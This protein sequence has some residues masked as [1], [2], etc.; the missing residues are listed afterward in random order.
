MCLD[1]LALDAPGCGSTQ[2]CSPYLRKTEGAMGGG[3]SVFTTVGLGREE[4]GGR[5]QYVM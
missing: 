5:D 1:L 3:E 4:G 2:G